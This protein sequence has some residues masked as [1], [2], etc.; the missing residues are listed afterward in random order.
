[1]PS[2]RWERSTL[3]SLKNVE[4]GLNSAFHGLHELQ[5]VVDKARALMAEGDYEGVKS[6]M[7]KINRTLFGVVPLYLARESDLRLWEV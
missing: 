3:K 2:L 7:R 5:E 1:M 6:C 4:T